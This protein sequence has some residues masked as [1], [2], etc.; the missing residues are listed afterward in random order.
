MYWEIQAGFEKH[1][2]LY[3]S[4]FALKLGERGTSLSIMSMFLQELFDEAF[5]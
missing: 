3:N 2:L 4:I 1:G 5:V